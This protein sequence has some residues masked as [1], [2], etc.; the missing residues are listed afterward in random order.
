[1][2]ASTVVVA[3]LLLA[4]CS[5]PPSTPPPTNDSVDEGQ[6]PVDDGQPDVENGGE[7]RPGLTA[8]ACEEQGGTVVGDIGDGAIHQ[9]D[10]RCPDSGEAPIGTITADPDGPVAIEGA[11]C[12]K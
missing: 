2:R 3:L 5:K 10:Y 6:P 9:P 7:E 4:A 8:A 12:C 1:M 11:V